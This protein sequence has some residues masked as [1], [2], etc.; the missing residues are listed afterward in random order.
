MGE[1]KAFIELNGVPLWRRQ[2]QILEALRPHELL[3]AGPAYDEWQEMNC[4]IISDAAPNAGPLA[5]IVAALQR[6]FA[7]LLLVLAIDL[8]NMSSRHL[9]GLVHACSA[10][11][12]IVP[13]HGAR[14][15]PLAAV[16]PT[17][18]LSLA[19]QCLASRDLSVQRFAARCVTE[20]FAVEKEITPADRP[21]FL[22]MNTPN[23]LALAEAGASHKATHSFPNG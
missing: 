7:P 21:L 8:P 15:E 16:Y 2:L 22:N 23:D 5:G 4:T 18:A 11:C 1:D 9:R 17:R 20:G 12:G 19:E 14:S 10:D 13:S 3:V 6:C